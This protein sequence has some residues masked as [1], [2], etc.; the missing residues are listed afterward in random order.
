MIS[1]ILRCNE[2]STDSIPMSHSEIIMK[3]VE[4]GEL[5]NKKIEI[6]KKYLKGSHSLFIYHPLDLSVHKRT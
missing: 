6:L 5:I 4:S 3:Y 2:A 1:S